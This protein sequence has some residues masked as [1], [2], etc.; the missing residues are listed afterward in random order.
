MINKEMLSVSV[1]IAAQIFCDF[2]AVKVESKTGVVLMQIDEDKKKCKKKSLHRILSR[3]N[4]DYAQK[5]RILSRTKS[6]V[7]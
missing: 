3:A 5:W 7:W 2:T 4:A 1:D 6:S